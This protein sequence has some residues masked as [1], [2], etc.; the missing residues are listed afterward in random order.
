MTYS[1]QELVGSPLYY[2]Q[3]YH[4]GAIEWLQK[5]NY[6]INSCAGAIC[7]WRMPVDL[8]SSGCWTT[9][10]CCKGILLSLAIASTFLSPE[11]WQCFKRKSWN[12][13][14]FAKTFLDVQMWKREDSNPGLT[15]SW[16]TWRMLP[17]RLYGKLRAH[18]APC[19]H[20]VSTKNLDLLQQCLN[21]TT[22][23]HEGICDSTANR[24]LQ[25][26]S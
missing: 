13:N 4:V 5:F 14:N 16:P 23:E 1:T 25:R 22:Y 12:V 15:G 24:A 19:I 18:L 21:V 11:C 2:P 9:Y 20:I 17:K 26:F 6:V 7:S 8:L 10:P 3:E